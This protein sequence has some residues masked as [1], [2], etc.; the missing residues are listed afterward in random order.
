MSE[1]IRPELDRLDR[2]FRSA[3]M[4]FFVRRIHDRSEAEDL[5]QEVFS[6]LTGAKSFNE[7]T[8]DAYV[9]RVASNLLDERRRRESVRRQYREFRRLE[10]F[11]GIDPLDPFRIAAGR[12]QI[13]HIAR[14][15]ADLPEK[16]RRVFVL[17]CM[18]N[19]DKATIAE[20]FGL[21]TR[22]IEIHLRRAL[23]TLAENV[24]LE[25]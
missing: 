16:T 10:D 3:L 8:P 6:R 13:A 21:S 14:C 9:F 19:I 20:S 23:D 2:R 15:L 5:T 7:T 22:M 18:E 17:Y 11:A 25:G 24:E 1:Q 4:A 12:D